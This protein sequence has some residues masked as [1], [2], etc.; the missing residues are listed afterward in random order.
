MDGVTERASMYGVMMTVEQQML[1]DIT[2][3]LEVIKR[4]LSRH[5]PW[6]TEEL[7]ELKPLVNEGL[8]GQK[9]IID[10]VER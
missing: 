10:G 3:Q 9:I 1:N 2:E 6:T 4:L 8:F 7:S 5:L